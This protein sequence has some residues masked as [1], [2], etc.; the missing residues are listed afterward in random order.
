MGKAVAVFI[1]V[2]GVIVGGVAIKKK[3]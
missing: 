3:K 2:I 1:V